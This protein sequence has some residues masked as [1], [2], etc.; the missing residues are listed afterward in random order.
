MPV[1]GSGEV[2]IKVKSVGLC[3]S[4]FNVYLGTHPFACYPRIPGHEV[5]GKVAES[6]SGDFGR[7]D[8]VCIE[9]YFN[10]GIC[11]PCRRGVKNCCENNRTMGVQRDG[12]L[13]EYVAVPSDKVFKSE[14]NLGYEE[15]A[16]VEPIS[17]GAH[18][19]KRS[20]LSSVDRALVIGVG[21]IGLGVVQ[22]AK[23]MGS[24]VTVSDMN[25]SRL[26]LAELLGA[27]HTVNPERE[28]PA[29]K[30]SELTGGDG[31]DVVFEVSGS[32]SGFLSAIDSAAFGGR[33][34]LVGTGTEEVTFSHPIVVKKELDIS[35]SRNSLSDFPEII[36][37]IEKGRIDPCAMITDRYSF[38][39][40]DRA[41]KLADMPE[42]DFIKVM[43]NLPD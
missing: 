7:G 6:H 30:I 26:D 36:G 23:L 35:G 5:S 2:L 19:V 9:P 22:I 38:G 1:P 18:A 8:R 20:G 12:A 42:R 10:C 17:I 40:A 24:K 31:M 33:V 11:Y 3:G 41:I 15:L 13:C 29:S 39:D 25:Q 16:L 27:D 37:W 21:P 43:I 32:A 28:D 14:R 34:V 4:D